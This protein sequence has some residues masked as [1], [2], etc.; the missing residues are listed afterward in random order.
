MSF[1][2]YMDNIQAKTGKSPSDFKKGGG[3]TFF[4]AVTA[5]SFS[6][7]CKE[8]KRL[9]VLWVVYYFFLLIRRITLPL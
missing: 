6:S 3:I 2:A 5:N 8:L 1:Q 9:G 7:L 4:Y